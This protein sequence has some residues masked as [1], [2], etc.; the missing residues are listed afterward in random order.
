MNKT[1]TATNFG[2]Q[3]TGRNVDHQSS[4]SM[5]PTTDLLQEEEQYRL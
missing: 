4:S 3:A 2:L 1:Q 5:T